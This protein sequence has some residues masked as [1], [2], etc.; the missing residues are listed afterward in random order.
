M[1]GEL[2]EADAVEAIAA[3]EGD[4]DLFLNWKTYHI[5]GDLLRQ[6]AVVIDVSERIRDRL[7]DEP[8]PLIF[9]LHRQRQK[10]IGFSVAASIAVISAGWLIFQ[11]AEQYQAAFQEVHVA[12]KADKKTFTPN[13]ITFQ[14][15]SAYILPSVP[16]N[17]GYGSY[18]STPTY[19]G[20]AH[21]DMTRYPY[22]EMSQAA[23]SFQEYSV[24]PVE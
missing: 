12:E 11:P 3:I 5:I 13:M 22:A 14:P 15:K 23:E 16:V 8:V 19:R 20:L 24:V 9:H 1:D 10:T 7:S 18:S 17:G 4:N 6:P 21:G 2:G